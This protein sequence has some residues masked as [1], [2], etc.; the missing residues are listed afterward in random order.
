MNIHGLMVEV[1]RLLCSQLS[2]SQA[3]LRG[4]CE[5]RAGGRGHRSPHLK[6]GLCSGPSVKSDG[7]GVNAAP[8]CCCSTWE[9]RRALPFLVCDG[10]R[11]NSLFERDGST[12]GVCF[13]E[14][15]LPTSPTNLTEMMGVTPQYQEK[16][17]CSQ[18]SD[19]SAW[20]QNTGL[21]NPECLRNRTQTHFHNVCYV[22]G[23]SC[24]GLCVFV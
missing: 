14:L 24:R 13:V 11:I 3:S 5:G 9:E 2:L 22:C 1:P 15:C 6:G 21:A 4:T 16:S 12:L 18:W 23:P 17:E 8:G 20:I 10:T 7:G 19:L